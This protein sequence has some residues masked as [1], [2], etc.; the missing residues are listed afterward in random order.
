MYCM[1]AYYCK[2]YVN[3]TVNYVLYVSLLLKVLCKRDSKL[4]IVCKL[5]TVDIM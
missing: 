3:E 5:I 2:Y 1:S 4:G